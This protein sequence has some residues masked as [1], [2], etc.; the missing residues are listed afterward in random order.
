[1]QLIEPQDRPR[2]LTVGQLLEAFAALDPATPVVV[3]II[4]GDRFDAADAH[5]KVCGGNPA[6]YILCHEA[7]RPWDWEGPKA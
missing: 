2:P 6:A 5:P 3:G 1:M 4:N 7:A